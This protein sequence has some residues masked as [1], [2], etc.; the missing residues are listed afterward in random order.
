MGL[1]L[2]IVI[3]KTLALR[4]GNEHYARSA[5]FWAKIFA[6]NFTFGVVTGIPME[7]QFGT[8]W[9]RFS[10]SAGGVIGQT[11]AMEGVFSFF[12]ESSFLGLFI[13]GEKRL[14]PIAH[15]FSAFLVFLG[16][17]L[18]GFFIIM[19]D[20][21]MQHPTGYTLGPKGEIMLSDFWA[22]LLNPWGL[23]Q[24]LHNMI[25][26]VVTGSFVMASIGA[27]YLLTGKHLHYGRTFVRT[28]V[29]AGTIAVALLL[30]PTGDQQGKM[31]LA[32]QPVTLAAM[33][34]LFDTAQ[35]APLAILGQPD[36]DKMQL[37][38]PILI[39]NALSFLTYQT[40]GAEVKGLRAFPRDLWPDNVP[41]LYFAYHIMVGLGT[42]MLALMALSLL[43]LRKGRLFTARPVLWMLML[44]LPFP[45][46]ATTA[47]WMT[48]E[49]GRQPWLIYGLMRTAQ[50]SSPQVSAGNGLFTLIGFM[51]LYLLLGVLFLFLIGREIEHGPEVE[52]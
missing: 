23:W 4:T 18:S 52:A 13:F 33:E 41:L 37:D 9:A 11:L 36:T 51:G 2:L 25:A 39:P 46:I 19:T 42:M 20:A 27:Y 24:Y 35:G 48:A 47:G 32:N 30:F 1:A 5:R 28:G 15:W 7:F 31:I 14:G 12:L 17:W 22:F 49:I 29:V 16:S 44:A 34:G 26:T 40:W 8:N 45:Y 21:W 6:I 38:N 3:L 43:L 10:R 50:G